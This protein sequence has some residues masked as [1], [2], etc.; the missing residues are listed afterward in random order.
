MVTRPQSS[1]DVFLF[2]S[3][4]FLIQVKAPEGVAQNLVLDPLGFAGAAFDGHAGTRRGEHVQAVGGADR[5]NAEQVRA[6][7]D[8]H[9][10]A[11]AVGAGDHGDAAPTPSVL[12][13]SV[14]AMMADSGTPMLIRYSRPTRALG[15]L[16]A[17]V[18][19]QRDDQRRD[20][21]M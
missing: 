10:A 15:E 17:A 8:D 20:A 5:V 1:P 6:V 12:R 16:V 21:A 7:A 2:Q 19:A 13:L 18:A 4:V 3:S 14:S 9:Q 11:Q